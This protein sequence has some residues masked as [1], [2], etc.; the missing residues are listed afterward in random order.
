MGPGADRQELEDIAS[1]P[2]DDFLFEVDGYHALFSIQYLLAIKAC[3]SKLLAI[4]AC[5]SKL[6]AQY[7][8]FSQQGLTQFRRKK[9]LT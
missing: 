3:H 6:L 8:T 5:H 2:Y 9:K 7:S 1:K 4:K